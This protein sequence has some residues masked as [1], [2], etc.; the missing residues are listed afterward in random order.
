MNF[1]GMWNG[2][3]FKIHMELNWLDVLAAI[4]LGFALLH[5]GIY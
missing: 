4:F 3:Q 2:M 1:N 5:G